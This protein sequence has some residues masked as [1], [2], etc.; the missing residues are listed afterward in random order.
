LQK[1]C[2]TR[3]GPWVP[4]TGVTAASSINMLSGA[5]TFTTNQF[6]VNTN[7][8]PTERMRIASNGSV[9]IGA[10][11][12]FGA[13][14]LH[15]SKSASISTTD[16]I[17]SSTP[18]AVIQTPSTGALGFSSLMF[19]AANAN[20]AYT[21]ASL[22]L[23]PVADYRGAFVA[24]YTA[25]GSGGYFA[26][27]Q[28]HPS[29]ATTYERLRIDSNGR[30]G[31]GSSSP[32]SGYRLTIASSDNS[33]RIIQWQSAVQSD[34]NPYVVGGIDLADVPRDGVSSNPAAYMRFIN[35]NTSGSFPTQIRGLDIA[36]GTVDGNSGQGA[37]AGERMRINSTGNVG[38]GTT[39]PGSDMSWASPTLDIS[40]S[41]GSLV[42]RTTGTSGIA[43]LR[44]KGPDGN[45]NDDW[46]VNMGAGTNSTISFSPKA[47]G[48]A[49]GLVLK[50]DG[51]VGIGTATPDSAL[52]VAGSL[53]TNNATS[54]GVR[55]GM[56]A[57]TYA[58]I[59]MVSASGTSGWID[60][61]DTGG[62]DYSERIRGGIGELQF[63]SN[64]AGTP[65]VKLKS[66][67]VLVTRNAPV[68]GNGMTG[69]NGYAAYAPISMSL[70]MWTYYAPSVPGYFNYAVRLFR[71][72]PS[73]GVDSRFVATIYSR[74]DL[75]Y[76]Y[77]VAETHIDIAKWSNSPSVYEFWAREMSGMTDVR[78]AMD[79]SGYVWYYFPQ[80]WSQDH[81]M[82]IHRMT[83]DAEL[84]L[85]NTTYHDSTFTWKLVQAGTQVNQENAWGS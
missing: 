71:M 25:D 83:G 49:V 19:R 36:F 58:A 77:M 52:H 70:P 85:T 15:I 66:D 48:G 40:G 27:N 31:I 23:A 79:S 11:S 38:I 3:A 44:F 12:S 63:F 14:A 69:E 22:E 32:T 61:H 72:N 26:V 73:T 67:G 37:T 41:R 35:R 45:A 76:S 34:I 28:F 42:L 20:N 62:A 82:V 84:A 47:G 75:N 7:F 55:A 59:D 65:Q 60:F 56:Y 80:L 68:F 50:N 2:A 24:T 64:G 4:D 5:I 57:G 18:T 46:H 13:A 16:F 54:I 1:V 29:N 21:A 10:S 81:V 9:S 43:T 30:V 17:Y 6:T 51:G 33:S 78:F 74:G 8:T 39:T 53:F